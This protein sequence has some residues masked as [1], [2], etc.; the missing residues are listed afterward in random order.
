VRGFNI[1]INK[2]ESAG[3]TVDHA[4]LHLITKMDACDAAAIA[5]QLVG[6]PGISTACATTPRGLT[7]A[8]LVCLETAPAKWHGGASIFREKTVK[9]RGYVM[10]EVRA[11]G[12]VTMGMSYG[13]RTT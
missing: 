11:D 13:N 5:V 9:S 4:H 7:F 10:E 8:E 2:G 12:G 6:R 1:G 3:Q